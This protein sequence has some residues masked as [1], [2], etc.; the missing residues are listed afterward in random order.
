MNLIRFP[1]STA[2]SKSILPFALHNPDFVIL[3]ATVE[4]KTEAKRIK[5]HLAEELRRLGF[6]NASR[7]FDEVEK[8][9]GKRRTEKIK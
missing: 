6:L 3:P 5:L 2:L 4:T 7:W 1:L 9:W 8:I